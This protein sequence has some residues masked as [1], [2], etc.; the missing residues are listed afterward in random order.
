MILE[1]ERLI[2]R[3][4]E[5]S[6]AEDFYRYASD[7]A[8]GPIA[9]WPV[10]TS[11]ENSREI[12]RDFFSAD[13]TY[14]V[15][16]KSDGRPIGS[17]GLIPPAQANTAAKATEMEVGFWVGVPH[18]GKGYIPEALRE[19]Q[20][21]AFEDMGCTALWCGYYD[22]N[23]KSERV[24][25]KCGFTYHHIVENVDCPL[26]N[27]TRT[28]HFRCLSRARWKLLRELNE[29]GGS[30]IRPIAPAELCLLDDF[31]CEAIFVPDG[32]GKPSRS[33]VEDP[34]YR[35]YVDGFGNSKH[36][37]ILVAEAGGQIVGC[38]LTRIMDDRGHVD[39]ETPSLLILLLESYRGRGIGTM[40][41]EVM[42]A[43]LADA[44]FA[45]TSLFVQK[46][47]P[48]VRFFVRLGFEI[49][50]END[51]EFIMVRKLALTPSIERDDR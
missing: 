48:A 44:G 4:W 29:R 17:I 40:L 27:D 30:T 23:V 46:E 3:P 1:T 49:V 31:L 18:W 45:K 47:N 10:H 9:G 13:E 35:V 12:I 41:M 14:A 34:A 26:V 25:Q 37:R 33:I 36:D 16:L 11:V 43:E 20:L 21:H 32:M 15:C 42:L 38:C 51:E 8:V 39:D 19:I 6:D 5:E 7:P 50:G 2:L 22:G 24:Q 28:E